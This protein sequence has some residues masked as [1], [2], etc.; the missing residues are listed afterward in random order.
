MNDLDDLVPIIAILSAVALPIGFSL[1]LGLV[2]LRTKH[3]ENLELIKQGIVPATQAKPT[4]NKYRSLRN[5][6][7]CVGIAIGLILGI[8]LKTVLSLSEDTGFFILAACILLF[9]GLA[10]IL[11]YLVTK[12]KNFDE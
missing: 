8:I 1:Y 12:D 6:F 4:P 10:Y 5:G 9:L 2:G 11:F 7:L 3:K